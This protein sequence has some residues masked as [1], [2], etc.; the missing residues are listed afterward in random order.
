M[1]IKA[2]TISENGAEEAKFGAFFRASMREMAALHR[3]NQ[4]DDAEIRR[5]QISTRKKLDRIRENLR[6]VQATN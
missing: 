2:A 6:P 5:L 4:A 3:A 1:K